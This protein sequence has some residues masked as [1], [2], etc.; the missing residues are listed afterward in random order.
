MKLIEVNTLTESRLKPFQD[1]ISELVLRHRSLLDIMSKLDQAS[2]AIHRSVTKA[3]TE[4]GCITL[5][6]QKQNFDDALTK[7]HTIAQLESHLEGSLCESCREAVSD[8]LGTHLFYMS[9]LSNSLN[10]NLDDVIDK[11]LTKCNTLG[12]FN[13]S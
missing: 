11:E 8:K 9:A 5:N 7:E 3:V 13:M 6:A 4:C 10:I 2:A 12:F 1:Q